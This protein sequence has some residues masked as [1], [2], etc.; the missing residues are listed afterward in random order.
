[1]ERS[2]STMALKGPAF[3]REKCFALTPKVSSSSERRPRF[4]AP[5]IPRSPGILEDEHF[6]SRME[7]VLVRFYAIAGQRGLDW[8]RS[9]ASI[10][11]DELVHITF[12]ALICGLDTTNTDPARRRRCAEI[13]P[14]IRKRIAS[15][16][17]VQSQNMIHLVVLLS[18]Q[19]LLVW[20]NAKA[21]MMH[22]SGLSAIVQNL[23]PQ[24]FKGVTER[25]TLHQT[26]LFLVSV[27][28]FD[29]VV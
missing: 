5:R 14:A 4:F 10:R 9:V 2:C 13:L 16:N 11:D 6:G 18:Y 28:L 12:K 7:H 19:E 3:G 1:M 21:W 17:A 15:A 26:R 25:K 8:L 20:N 24:A 23:G 22:I 29:T 27:T